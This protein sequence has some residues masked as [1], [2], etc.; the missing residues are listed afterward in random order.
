MTLSHLIRAART[1]QQHAARAAR[2]L[3]PAHPMAGRLLAIAA[4]TAVAA[5]EAGHL[6][7]DIHPRTKEPRG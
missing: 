1:A 2:S 4:A 3:G 7:H 6:V 5:W